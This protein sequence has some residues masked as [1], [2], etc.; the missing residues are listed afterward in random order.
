MLYVPRLWALFKDLLKRAESLLTSHNQ[1]TA[2]TPGVQSWT[3]HCALWTNELFGG[4]LPPSSKA[5]IPELSAEQCHACSH[6]S[7]FYTCPL[8]EIQTA[9]KAHLMIYMQVNLMYRH[10]TKAPSHIEHKFNILQLNTHHSSVA[11]HSLLN[12]PTTLDF[13]FLL[14]W[15]PYLYPENHL[16]IT[17]QLWTLIQPDSPECLPKAHQED[18]TTKSLIYANQSVPST[19]MTTITTNSN[20]SSYTQP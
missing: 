20:S 2:P 5:P 11:T 14:I 6:S 8:R 16:P 3:N 19:A 4:D 1:P 13:H 7:F 17:H 15:E 10:N 12:N 9:K 18:T